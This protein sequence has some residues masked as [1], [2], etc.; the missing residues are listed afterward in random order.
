M[1]FGQSRDIARVAATCRELREAGR[2]DRCWR[3]IAE[4]IWQSVTSQKIHG[5]YRAVGCRR[6]S[7]VNTCLSRSRVLRFLRR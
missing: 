6:R 4:G 1:Q 2:D 3:L 7:V 5:D